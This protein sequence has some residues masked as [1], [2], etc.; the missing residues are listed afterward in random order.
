MAF[1]CSF[2]ERTW[3]LL[4]YTMEDVYRQN[5]HSRRTRLVPLGK[6]RSAGVTN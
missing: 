4:G 2:A 3:L 6:L 1:A 5:C